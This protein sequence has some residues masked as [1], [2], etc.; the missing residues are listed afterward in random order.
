MF[1][2]SG[3]LIPISGELAILHIGIVCCWGGDSGFLAKKCLVPGPD[4]N[5]N[6]NIGNMDFIL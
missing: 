6:S 2:A 5:P 1:A 4:K 3:L